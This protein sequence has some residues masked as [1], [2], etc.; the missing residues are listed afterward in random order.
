MSCV[1][2]CMQPRRR[3][4]ALWSCADT[5]AVICKSRYL[6]SPLYSA[7][8]LCGCHAQN[9]QET[10]LLGAFS[11]HSMMRAVHNVQSLQACLICGMGRCKMATTLLSWHAGDICR[12]C[13]NSQVHHFC[14]REVA[15]GVG[16]AGQHAS[17]VTWQLLPAACHQA[18]GA[19]ASAALLA[20]H[21]AGLA[22]P[23]QG[24]QQLSRYS[25]FPIHL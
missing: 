3:A 17:E 20:H 10:L 12:C 16:E 13:I 14:A 22:A 24:Q 9:Y 6:N 2:G 4:S 21:P 23:S 8:G 18:G 11:R 25:V 1:A 7:P 19:H 5:P 15:R